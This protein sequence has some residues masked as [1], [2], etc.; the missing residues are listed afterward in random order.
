MQPWT[1]IRRLDVP[2]LNPPPVEIECVPADMYDAV[3]AR[4]AGAAKIL[5]EAVLFSPSS[6]R[7]PP[8]GSTNPKSQPL[9]QIPQE[10]AGTSQRMPADEARYERDD[11]RYEC[12]ELRRKLAA[13]KD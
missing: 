11:L 10:N 1:D 3:R 4:A 8:A 12:A 9:H 2:P 5:R 6:I 13:E 7:Q